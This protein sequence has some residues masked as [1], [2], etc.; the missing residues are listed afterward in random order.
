MLVVNIGHGKQKTT[1]D[2]KA[3]LDTIGFPWEARRSKK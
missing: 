3:Q 1:V 2:E